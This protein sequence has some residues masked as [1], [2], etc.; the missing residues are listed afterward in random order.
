MRHARRKRPGRGGFSLVELIVVIAIIGILATVVIVRFAGKTDQ[1]RV[2]AAKSQIAQLEG[3]V[4]E[5]EA[6]C[7]RMPRSL[8]E[9][10]N[11]PSDAPHW[12]E[13]GYL[14]NKRVSKDPWQNEYV[15][16]TEGSSFEIVCLGSDGKEGGTGYAKDISSRDLD[17]AAE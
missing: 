17:G 13:G 5:F 15:Y 9:L 2:A 4:V 16:R 14:K 7:G 1:A 8:D 10:V 12:Q 6:H 11:K 3:A